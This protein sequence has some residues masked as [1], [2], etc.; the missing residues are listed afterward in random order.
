M[1][2]FRTISVDTP[3]N[4]SA[5]AFWKLQFVMSKLLIATLNDDS[6]DMN[7]TTLLPTKCV[8]IDCFTCNTCGADYGNVLKSPIECHDVHERRNYWVLN[9]VVAS[10]YILSNDL[11]NG[12]I[13]NVVS[14]VFEIIVLEIHSQIG[15]PRFVNEDKAIST[16]T[17]IYV[18]VIPH[19]NLVND[20]HS[21]VIVEQL[22]GVLGAGAL[23][24]VDEGVIFI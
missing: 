7:P 23:Q 24:G 16:E 2:K 11:D 9:C 10:I 12:H 19:S 5:L 14:D 20:W 22:P 8:F 18:Y 15:D 3:V 13:C 1:V 21:V 17:M 6:K 4:W